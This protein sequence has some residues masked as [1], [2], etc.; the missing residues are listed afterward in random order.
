MN[1]PRLTE[2]L[3]RCHGKRLLVVGDLMLDVYVAGQ[4]NRI[5][6]EA[7]V[8]VVRIQGERA[9][10]GGCGNVARNLTPYGVQVQMCAV[11]GR[12][13]NGRCVRDLLARD[14]I[15]AAGVFAD[16]ARP[17]TTKT[18]ITVQRQQILRLDREETV[19]ISGK[20]EERLVAWLARAIPRTA[21][22]LMSDYAKGL[23]SDRVRQAVF[24]TAHRSAIPVV[25]D[26][27]LP[28]LRAYRGATVL[29][30]NTPELA[31]AW[32][33]PIE[34][35]ADL[36][37]AGQRLRRTSQCAT[38][39]VTRGPLPTAVFEA[40]KKVAYVP[41]LAREVYDV[42]GAGDT[43]LAFLGL[44]LLGGADY[45]EA[46]EIANVAAGIV[47]GKVGTARVERAELLTL[48]NS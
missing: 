22:V 15:G 13:E 34:N 6:P 42:S 44:G 43:M 28:D 36:E 10:L 38:L 37:R 19:P 26:P 32:G 9:M 33:H 11:V 46:V 5:C 45:V 8:Q 47:V 12:D 16:S 30:P 14:A 29:K 17:T 48:L 2:I 3:D 7:P 1:T 18:R 41:T 31:K 27:K 40:G 39:V 25:V 4:V 20:V 21:V 35:E 23:L 24:E